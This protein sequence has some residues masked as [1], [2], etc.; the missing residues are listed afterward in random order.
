MAAVLQ[1]QRLRRGWSHQD[2]AQRT[3]LLEERL[4][5]LEITARSM[6]VSEL[7]VLADAFEVTAGSLVPLDHP[8][9]TEWNVAA[10]DVLSAT[11]GGFRAKVCVLGKLAEWKLH[12]HGGSHARRALDGDRPAQGLDAVFESDEARTC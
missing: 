9:E 1:Q 7:A 10:W 3:R 4:R 11:A 5:D 6:T 8:L 2:V 12:Q